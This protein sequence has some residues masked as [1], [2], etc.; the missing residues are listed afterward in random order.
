MHASSSSQT[1]RPLLV[2]SAAAVYRLTALAVVGCACVLFA[3][4]TFARGDVST[5]TCLAV[6]RLPVLLAALLLQTAGGYDTPLTPPVLVAP[7]S[8]ARAPVAPQSPLASVANAAQR[9]SLQP[10]S[11]VASVLT[12]PHTLELGLQCAAAV[13]IA[14]RLFHL[15]AA[16]P[17]FA[18]VA[19]LLCVLHVVD[20]AGV[21]RTS[22]LRLPGSWLG[23]TRGAF[24]LSSGTSRGRWARLGGVAPAAVSTLL[25]G[26]SP[27]H[28]AF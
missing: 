9:L 24:A 22:P 16:P 19:T 1:L 15:P 17:V 13:G 18:A 21:G 7:P 8:R 10:F 12:H 26:P 28:P 2:T 27:P 4:A 5:F 23:G 11:F 6:W 3:L 14:V 25:A 20:F